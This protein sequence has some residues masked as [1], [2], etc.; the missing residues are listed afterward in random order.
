MLWRNIK[1]SQR[2]RES[3]GR[4]TRG[5]PLFFIGHLGKVLMKKRQKHKKVRQ[6]SWARA[7]RATETVCANVLRQCYAQHVG[8]TAR[9][10]ME[11]KQSD[12]QTSQVGNPLTLLLGICSSF[13]FSFP[14]ISEMFLLKRMVT[15][16]TFHFP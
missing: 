5:T 8:G 11:L 13:P 15:V 10:P 2:N 1:S 12:F 16:T 6:K 4:K 7:F 3:S 14:T 9:K